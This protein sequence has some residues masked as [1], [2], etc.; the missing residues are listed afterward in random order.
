[1]FAKR[2]SVSRSF[3]WI[4]ELGVVCLVLAGCG[5]GSK[6]VPQFSWSNP[7][8]VL[9]GTALSATQLDATASVPG[10][11]AYS[12]SLGAVLSAGSQTLSVTFTPTDTSTYATVTASVTLIV[13]PLATPA[14][15][16]SAPAAITYG[17]PLSATQLSA[18]ESVPGAFAY[19]PALGAVI[20]AGTQT[21]SVTFTPTDTNHT[22]VQASVPITVNQAA[23]QLSWAT[24][25]AITYGTQLS[26]TQL[27]AS[28]SVPGSYVYLP[29]SGSVLTAGSQTL[30]V[31]FTPTDTTDYTNAATSVALTVNQATPHISWSPRSWL[32]VGA[33]LGSGQL[34]ATANAPGSSALLGGSFVYTPPAG[35]TFNAAGPQSLSVTFTPSDRTD[36]TTAQ[37]NINLTASVFGVAAWGDSLTCGCSGRTRGPYPSELQEQITLPVLN[38]GVSGNTSTQIGVREGGVP[39]TVTIDGGIIPASGGVTVTFPS[40]PNDACADYIPVTP[41]GPA[42]GVSGTI[43]GVHGTVTIDST[44]TILTFTRTSSGSAVSASGAPSFVVDTPYANYLP[45]FWEGR[46]DF[47]ATAQILSDLAGQ[48]ATVPPGQDYLVLSVINI[49][50]PVEWYGVSGNDLYQWVIP[51]NEQLASIYGSHYIDVRKLLVDAYDPTQ[52]TD[53]TDYQHDEPPTSLRALDQTATLANSIGPNDTTITL[54][55]ESGIPGVTSIVKIDNGANAENVLVTAVSGKTLTVTRSFGGNQTSHA[56]GAPI[57]QDDEVHLNGKG[58]QVV[59]NAVAQYLSAY[60]K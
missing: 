37:T 5:G 15:T 27:N 52:A 12:P 23:P 7:S 50:R 3:H 14:I 51:F 46:N 40:C 60:E 44:G 45:V 11:F 29:A 59:A 55:N 34:N 57:E 39:T 26:G 43:L 47:G 16:W 1:M 48:V 22:V 54:A 33:P 6:T 35:T 13:N 2:Y 17:T 24:P 36:F 18:M 30:S 58:Y 49:N 41:Y 19:S 42:G 9:Y 32:A 20:P 8:P 4:V 56:A 28:S 38:L 31:T 53:V 21:L 25:A 10:T